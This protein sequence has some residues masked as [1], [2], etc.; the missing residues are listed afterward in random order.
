M[1]NNFCSKAAFAAVMGL[2]AL[3]TP[4]RADSI[5]VGNTYSGSFNMLVSWTPGS[6]SVMHDA[7]GGNITGSVGNIHGTDYAFAVF[8]CADLFTDASLSTTYRALYNAEGV[9]GAST[10]TNGGQIAWL[11]LN[12]APTLTTQSEY[13]GLQGLIWTLENPDRVRWDY[14]DNTSAASTWFDTFSRT[15]SSHTAPVGSIW[16]INPTNAQGQYAY[17]GF[18]A[19]TQAQIAAAHVPEPGTITLLGAGLAG[20]GLRRRRRT[21]SG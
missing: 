15:L 6:F 11:M 18:V 17:Q 20:I 12:I 14:A 5:T 21:G 3:N 8:Y 7:G 9:I 19:A 10:V 1:N 2:L 13:Q 4:A 16:W